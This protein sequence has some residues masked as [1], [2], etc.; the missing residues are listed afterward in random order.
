[1]TTPARASRLDIAQHFADLPD[2]RHWAF[3]GRHLLGDILVIGLS[4]VLAGAESWDGIAA[5]GVAK[6]GWL[7]S[8]GLALPNGIPSH[9]TFNRVFA[10]LDPVAFQGCF[11]GWIN[12]VC[13]ALG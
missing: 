8:L 11:R 5:F 13:A 6:Q 10:A 4:A 2:P 12:A 7:R 1:M 3:R 9:D